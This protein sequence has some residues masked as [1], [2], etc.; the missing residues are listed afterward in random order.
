[1]ATAL[2]VHMSV[3]VGHV[4]AY[5][6]NPVS[7]TAVSKLLLVLGK[8][9]AS[10]DYELSPIQ[11]LPGV[12]ATVQT[13]PLVFPALSMRAAGSSDGVGGLHIPFGVHTLAVP[14][15]LGSGGGG[16]EVCPTLGH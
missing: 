4:H 2:P 6:R 10:G 3:A 13:Q 15:A 14:N 5:P 9:L 11:S 12:R 7:H 8:L 16:G 1:M